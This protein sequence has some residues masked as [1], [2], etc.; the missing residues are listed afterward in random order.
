[1]SKIAPDQE[2][3][4]GPLRKP[5]VLVAPL[6][7]G[8]GH[9][10]RC[11]PIIYELLGQGASVW[12][13]AEGPQAELLQAEFPELPLLPLQGYGVRYS[14]QGRH[15]TR[16][17]LAQ[18][19]RISRRISQEHRW[20]QIMMQQYDFDL[21]LSDN[22]YGLY[23]PGA[24]CILITHQLQIQHHWGNSIKQL[25]HRW[26]YNRICRFQECWIPDLAS[27]DDLA[28]ELAHPAVMP[29]IPVHYTGH[30]SRLKPVSADIQQGHLFISLSGPEPQRTLLEE[31]IIEQVSHYAGTAVIVRGLPQA[32]RF[33]PSTG[34]IRFYNHLN[35]RDYA[36]E[37]QK[38]RW[39]ISRSGYSTIMDIAR[40]GKQSILIPTPGQ[41]EQEY[42]SRYLQQKHWA[43]AGD[44]DTFDL[45]HLLAQAQQF[46]YNIPSFKE[47]RLGEEITRVIEKV[48]GKK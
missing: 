13:A 40:M 28:G 15:F 17:I 18:L 6:D 44:Q 3:T 8:L 43:L 27:P 22:R 25:L 47:N 38:A 34:D 7:W 1:M 36:S 4:A 46:P 30:L 21:I 9:A 20:L 45:T 31:K 14:R 42:L 11:I 41:T 33:I 24:Y 35:S 12:L 23:H 37:M 16:T 29:N 5:R 32:S 48:K 10:T 39:V 26:H 2:F 19:P